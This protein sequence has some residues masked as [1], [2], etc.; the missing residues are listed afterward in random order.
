MQNLRDQ[1]NTLHKSLKNTAPNMK[2][3]P[4]SLPMQQMGPSPSLFPQNGSLSTPLASLQTTSVMFYV[5]VAIA[6][7]ACCILFYVGYKIYKKFYPSPNIYY[8]MG[9]SSTGPS[10]TGPSSTTGP[11][12]FPTTQNNDPNFTPLHQ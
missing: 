9:P 3:G 5:K 1:F 12:S 8:P 7:A 11:S 2:I 10:S 6:A 4:S